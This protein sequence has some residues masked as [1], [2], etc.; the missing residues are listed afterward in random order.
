MAN[1]I[2]RS[3]IVRVLDD[4]G[5]Y[6]YKTSIVKLVYLIDNVSFRHSGQTLSGLAYK[7]DHFGPNATEDEIVSELSLMEDD[8]LVVGK[9]AIGGETARVY[10]ATSASVAQFTAVEE[11]VINDVIRKYA[12]MSVD[13]LKQASKETQPFRYARQGRRLGMKRTD[14]PMPTIAP[15]DWERHL[16][17]K[18]ADDGVTISEIRAKYAAD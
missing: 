13:E 6:L 5:G 18:K 8:G 15:S 10:R 1:D 7:W 17:E 9:P 12:R 4:A 16:A 3:L 11:A 14:R 2:L